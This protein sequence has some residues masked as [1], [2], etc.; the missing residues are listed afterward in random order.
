MLSF[1]IF[2]KTDSVYTIIEEF[3]QFFYH[4]T[5]NRSKV[6]YYKNN[7]FTMIFI[8]ITLFLMLWSSIMTT[9]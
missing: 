5:K 3:M 1:F 6:F 7:L 4:L 2:Y 8:I 9:F